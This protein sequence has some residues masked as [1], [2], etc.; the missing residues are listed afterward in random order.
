LTHE[1]AHAAGAAKHGLA[2]QPVAEAPAAVRAAT[3]EKEH[4]NLLGKLGVL[5][6]TFTPGFVPGAIETARTNA[7]RRTQRGGAVGQAG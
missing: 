7:Q 2:P 6:A 4:P 1:A 3:L 5:V